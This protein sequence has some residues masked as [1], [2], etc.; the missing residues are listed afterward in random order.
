MINRFEDEPLDHRIDY[1]CFCCG[2]PDCARK[3]TDLCLSCEER[4]CRN[5]DKVQRSLSALHLERRTPDEA[6]PCGRC[7]TCCT[8]FDFDLRLR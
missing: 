4:L 7:D 3:E 6:L 5:C 1:P 2:E 8:C